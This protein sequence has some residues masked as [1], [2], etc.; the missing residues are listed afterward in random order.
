M[1]V[2]I[3]QLFYLGLYWSLF[4]VDKAVQR[5]RS[6]KVLIAVILLL[7]LWG[8]F[9]MMTTNVIA[10]VR[11]VDNSKILYIGESFQN[12]KADSTEE[13]LRIVDQQFFSHNFEDKFYYKKISKHI[14]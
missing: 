9:K 7:Q 10:N 14:D 2:S 8:Q 11:G 1:R 3:P 6:T 12:M 4:I 13:S 5:K